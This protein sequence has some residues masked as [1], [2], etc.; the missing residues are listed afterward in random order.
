MQG[1]AEPPRLLLIPC[2]V[3]LLPIYPN[4]LGGRGAFLDEFLPVQPPYANVV[5]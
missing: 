4:G 5:S 1:V 3:H 2:R